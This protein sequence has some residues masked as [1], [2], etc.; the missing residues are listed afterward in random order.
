MLAWPSESICIRSA[1]FDANAIA[2]LL[3]R[4]TCRTGFDEPGFCLFNA[5]REIDSVG[6][7]RMMVQLKRAMA[8]IHETA[9]GASLAY[10]STARFDQ[11][12]STKPHLDAGPE[13]SFLML[14]Y[15]PSEVEADLVITDY[16]RCAYDLG[17]TPKELLNR[18]NPMFQSSHE[19]L[20]PYATR[21]PCF[22]PA[23]Y[24][25]VCVN[26]SSAEYSVDASRW[27]GTLHTATIARP[28]EMLRR[29]INSTMIASVESGTPDVVSESE[30]DEFM[31][32]PVVR[33]RGYDKTHLEDDH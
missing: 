23:D 24:Q 31:K 3:Y 20:R 26:N 21:I 22:S 11:Q 18:H 10:L 4:R 6:F 12:S 30:I 19:V 25:I 29:V 2:G 33:R 32:T 16:S 7:R 14:G 13:E 1:S 5:G 28:N 27:Q 17:L 15:E 8:T 9:T